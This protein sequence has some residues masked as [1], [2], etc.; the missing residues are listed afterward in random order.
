MAD[1]SRRWNNSS[2]PVLSICA[3]YTEKG[4]AFVMSTAAQVIGCLFASAVH[5]KRQ[6]LRFLR[7]GRGVLT[8][9]I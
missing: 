1:K 6:Y 9:I 4:S 7:G 8:K 5:V 2:G 3:V